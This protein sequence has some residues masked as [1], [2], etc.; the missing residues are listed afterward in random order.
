MRSPDEPTETRVKR[1][2]TDT[3]AQAD[4]LIAQGQPLRAYDLTKR[5]LAEH[6]D[7]ARV[8]LRNA[9]ALRRCG[10]LG[11]ALRILDGLHGPDADGE[12]RGLIAAVHKEMFVRT[13]GRRQPD[14]LEHLQRAQRLYQEVFEESHG[15]KYWHG[16]NAATLAVLMGDDV[17]ARELAAR[18]WAAC[19]APARP[20][21]AYWLLATRAEAALV[22]G[23]LDVAADEY[24]NAVRVAGDRISDIAATRQNALL[25]LQARALDAAE[26]RSI[27]EALEPPAVVVFAGVSLD[28]L[29]APAAPFSPEI[30]AD[31][32]AAIDDRLAA[33]RAGFGFS[34]GAPGPDTLFIEAMLDRQ[35]GVANVV[36]PWPRAQ[37]AATHVDAAGREWR[38]RFDTLLGNDDQP[39]RVQHQVHATLGI[40]L[41]GP[42]YEGF[43]KQLLFG[44]A[45]LH[46][47]MLATHVVPVVVADG[48]DDRALE[49]VMRRW[50][51]Q[52]V[53]VAPD[54]VIDIARL[55]KGRAPRARAGRP[56]TAQQ[57]A[58]NAPVTFRVMA[59]LFA[60]VENYSKIPENR[61]P[62][63]IEHFVGGIAARLRDTPYR[64]EN[65]RRVGDGLLMIFASVRDAAACALDLVDWAGDGSRAGPDGSTRWS[66]VGLPHEMRIRVALHAGPIFECQDPLTH[67]TAFEGA[68]VNYAARIEPVTPGNQVYASEAFAALAA[69][70]PEPCDEFVCEYVGR[71]SLAKNF[72]DYPLYHLRRS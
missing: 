60:D 17:L 21:D 2:A 50:E 11:L 72:G 14:S 24:R 66:R 25:L 38:R 3:L 46:A 56:V 31:V 28:T 57:M 42:L 65:I 59:I 6:P 15:T 9:H 52:G 67:A 12:R 8:R 43:A 20:E 26:R 27:T 69:S 7:D 37:F 51:S 19:P 45:R 41:D 48:R 64:A 34:G 40:G 1:I 23:R 55:T 44:L 30:A 18:V 70:W 68:H 71:T 63:F 53:Q 47:R 32:R 62:S 33:L 4:G 29:D 54:N 10:A 49:E 16:I 58:A 35:P 36:L 61:L 39:P 5:L 13:R 22:Q